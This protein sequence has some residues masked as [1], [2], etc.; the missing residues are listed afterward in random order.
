MATETYMQPSIFLPRRARA[1]WHPCSLDLRFGV[2]VMPQEADAHDVPHNV[3]NCDRTAPRVRV[4]VCKSPALTH[5]R[6]PDESY[7]RYGQVI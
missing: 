2:R 6:C 5:M 3:C 4:C 7:N 1:H